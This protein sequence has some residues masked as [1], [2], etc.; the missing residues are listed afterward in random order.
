MPIGPNKYIIRFDIAMYEAQ[1][2]HMLHRLDE[3]HNVEPHFLLG[4]YILL[5]EQPHEVTPWQI[6]HHEIQKVGVLETAVQLHHIVSVGVCKY[7]LLEVDV[8][9]LI[10]LDHIGF[11]ES[12]DG[13]DLACVTADLPVE[14]S[15]PSRTS[16][17]DPRP[18]IL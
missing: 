3:L 17:N 11:L 1:G 2:V 13:D 18:I 12:L 14:R 8:I 6:L 5:Y 10:A 4:E 9:H 16:P 7:L 15:L